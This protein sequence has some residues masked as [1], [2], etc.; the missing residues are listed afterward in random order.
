MAIINLLSNKGA[1]HLGVRVGANFC[2]TSESVVII[3]F[4]LT[5][6]ADGHFS[7]HYTSFITLGMPFNWVF[8]T[9]YYL[10]LSTYFW[11]LILFYGGRDLFIAYNITYFCI[12]ITTN[13]EV[14]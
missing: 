14:I 13:Y 1:A 11:C 6:F 2:H 10:R 4:A 7:I 5:E 3:F 9:A 8:F 12:N